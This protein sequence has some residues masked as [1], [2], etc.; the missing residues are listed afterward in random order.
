MLFFYI[1]IA[2]TREEIAKNLGWV[3]LAPKEAN[4]C[5]GYYKEEVFAPLNT[6]EVPFMQGP[7]EITADQTQF[8]QQGVSTLS[9]KVIVTQP[10]RIINADKVK[11]TRDAN[12]GRLTTADLFGNVYLREP[13]RLVVSKKAH[14]LLTNKTGSLDEAIY[15][16]RLSDVDWRPL[17]Q[18]IITRQKNPA[19]KLSGWGSAEH[20]EAKEHN[21]LVLNRATYSTC[22]PVID[23]WTLTGK[24]IKLNRDTGRGEA[25]N[26]TLRVKDVPV[27]YAPYFNFPIDKRRQTGFLF[28]TISTSGS[29]GFAITTPYYFNLA[30]NYDL[31][32][33]PT[34]LSKRGLRLDGLFR[35][36]TPMSHGDLDLVVLP[37]DP[38]FADFQEDAANLYPPSKALGELEDASAT[39]R[40]LS[41]KNKTVFN[42][43][44]SSE[45]DYS[46]VSD[47][48]YFQDLGN[49]ESIVSTNQL[50]RQG[51]V[52]Y[53]GDNWVFLGQLQH[54]QTLHPVNQTPIANQY[55]SFPQLI[56]NG[57][58]PNQAYGLNYQFN[59]EY[60]YF[61]RDKGPLDTTVPPTASRFNI[62]PGISLPINRLYGYFTPSL[63]LA[64]T[65]Y[66]IGDQLPDRPNAIT[67]VLPIFNVDM[68]LYFD[69]TIKFLNTCYQQTLEP[70]LF[71]LFVPY[72]NQNDIPIFD[73]SLQPFS[74][75]QL[76][77]YNRFSGTDRISDANQIAAALTTRFLDKNTG[78][79]KLRASIG[80]I[81]YFRNRAVT[82]CNTPGCQD[83][84][85]TPG[86]TSTTE[87]I[88]PIVGKI[89]YYLSS[90][91]STIANLAWDPH[92]N[93]TIN[94]NFNFQ[95]S[96]AP[97]HIINLGYNYIR[98]GDRYASMHP[99][100]V[101]SR[102]NNLNQPNISFAWTVYD[103]WRMVGS[104]N[105][106]LSH[107]YPQTYFYGL[108]YNSCCWA[109]RLIA[110]RTFKSLNEHDTPVFNNAIYLQWQLKG[111]GTVGTSDPS[112]LLVSGIRGYVDNFGK[113]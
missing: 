81:Y 71:Y 20:A 80:Q 7:I 44:W 36:L 54:Y 55:S 11:L 100:P 29:S 19:G 58:Y 106:N 62:Q 64:T 82:L 98:F 25:H 110:G 18:Q 103:N 32:F 9:G 39:R 69:R 67:R 8:L 59:N 78:A 96:P 26:V 28:P 2:A 99:I 70:R 94:G 53:Q 79:E 93:H 105:Y 33:T 104:Y 66:F 52:Q 27:F 49:T 75:E 24:T 45:I 17:S 35:Y 14:I 108:E 86:A 37:H 88:S 109:V 4:V 89:N 77:R 95:Y 102:K 46:Y 15:R 40:F 101:T 5:G 85:F 41:W 1:G 23:S 43:H 38:A 56:L 22:P 97:D 51:N 3:P 47:D 113:F 107:S 61:T 84:L 30:P 72:K 57:N 91:W 6:R 112:N 34:L 10:D 76:F 83:S 60:I 87:D 21:V 16:I 31:T 74:Y 12:T 13:G 65:Q 48:Y 92:V 73:T 68:G 90:Q 50:L 63:Q 42:P 111:L